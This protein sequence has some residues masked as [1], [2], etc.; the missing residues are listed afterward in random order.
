MDDILLYKLFEK[1]RW[2]QAIQTAVEKEIDLS[3]LRELCTPEKRIE[4]YRSIRDGT[5]R[6][7]P[8]HEA[9]IPK[10]DGSMRT[11]YVNTGIDRIL[12]SIVNDMFF[13]LCPEMIHPRCGSYQKGI[14][15][16]K[17][18]KEMSG[19]I[20]QVRSNDIGVKV[21]LS[22][23]FDSVPRTLIDAVFDRIEQKFGTS[24]L[25][26]TIRTY[27]HTDVVI[28]MQKQKVEKY[29]SLRQG[30]AIAAFLA[31]AILYDVDAE[32]SGMNVKYIR[33]SDDILII[34]DQWNP[35]FVRLSEILAEKSLTLNPKKVEFLT[36]DKWFSFLGFMVKDDKI[37]LSPGRVKSF[38]KEIEKRTIKR[39]GKTQK[40]VIQSVHHYLYKG[41]GKYSWA[42]SVLPIINVAE[43][44]QTLNNFVMDAVR[45]AVLGR[46]KI[47]GLGVS[48]SSPNHAI[49]RGK[50]RNVASN[51]DRLPRLENWLTLQCARNAMLTSKEAYRTLTMTF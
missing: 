31:D 5:Y 47:G 34:G 30:C 48:K 22:K 44:I 25:M 35:A 12:L 41:D 32:I 9:Q 29:S 14:G 20:H 6:I 13:E 3:L 38:Q 33:Y 37:S 10:D 7:E 18:V 24:A 4:L 23:Y 19:H 26:K 2:E 15:C 16:G 49:L 36:K 42:T 51:W 45:A 1:H 46:T 50:G 27:Y 17:L 43:D 28:N 40:S 11:V 21:D 39:Q 8:P